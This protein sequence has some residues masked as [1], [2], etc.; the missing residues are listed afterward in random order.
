MASIR[1]KHQEATSPL[2]FTT[3]HHLGSNNADVADQSV[4]ILTT[5]AEIL[6]LSGFPPNVIASLRNLLQQQLVSKADRE[7][8]EMGVSEFIMADRL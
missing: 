5:G 1:D 4:S 3:H 2:R 7:D 6:R 8:P